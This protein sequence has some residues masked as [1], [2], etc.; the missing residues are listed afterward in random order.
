V[1]PFL[2]KDLDCARKQ[3]ASID[4]SPCRAPSVTD[5][6]ID[7]STA[8]EIMNCPNPKP[9]IKTVMI[10]LLLLLGEKEKKLNVS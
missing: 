2:Q 4:P 6:Q 1:A 10:S 7:K 9:I 8:Q 3:L 5:K